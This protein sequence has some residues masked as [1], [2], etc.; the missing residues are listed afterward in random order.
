MQ[1]F[2]TP[3]AERDLTEI[4]SHIAQYNRQRSITFGLELEAACYGLATMPSA[5]AFVP[6]HQKTGIRR[7]PHGDY[8]IFYRVK[9]S[10]VEVVRVLHGARD[11]ERVLFPES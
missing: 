10:V 11:Y 4:C 5:Y 6:G 7:R 9:D 2:L 8:L 3:L 1:L